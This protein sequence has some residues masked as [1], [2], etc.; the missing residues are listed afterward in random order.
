MTDAKP[1]SGW[2]KW[3]S[4]LA[5]LVLWATSILTLVWGVS[6]ERAEV[7]SRINATITQAADHEARLRVLEKQ[8]NEMAADVRWIRQALEQ[9]RHAPTS[10]VWTPAPDA[11]LVDLFTPTWHPNLLFVDVPPGL[12]AQAPMPPVDT[13]PLP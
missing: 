9:M 7:I 1:Q 3:L 8:S 2:R 11:T 12:A 10:A 4:D 13:Q 6:A 5:I